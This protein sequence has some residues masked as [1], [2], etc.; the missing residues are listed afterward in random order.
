MYLDTEMCLDTFILK[1]YFMEQREYLTLYSVPQQTLP[2]YIDK[3]KHTWIRNQ[4]SP[5]ICF[6]NIV[7]FIGI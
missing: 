6:E 3:T 7:Y 1:T 5:I 4:H 2:Q